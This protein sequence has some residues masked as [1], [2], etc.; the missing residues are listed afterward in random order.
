MEQVHKTPN[1]DEWNEKLDMLKTPTALPSTVKDEVFLLN[2][3]QNVI[4]I[5][6]IQV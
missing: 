5:K 2:V 4:L 3:K 1:S 6:C